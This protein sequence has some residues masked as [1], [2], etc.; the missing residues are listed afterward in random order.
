MKR[1]FFFFSVSDSE[2]TLELFCHS[3]ERGVEVCQMWEWA[4]FNDLIIVGHLER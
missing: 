4:D 3:D 2:S 1:K